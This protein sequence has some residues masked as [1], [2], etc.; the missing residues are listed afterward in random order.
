MSE[1]RL[2]GC[3]VV[4][5]VAV[6]ELGDGGLSMLA[7]IATSDLLRGNSQRARTY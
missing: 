2:R 6:G 7:A 4:A 5:A 3:A 1:G